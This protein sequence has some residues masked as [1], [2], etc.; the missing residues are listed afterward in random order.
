[1]HN[2]TSINGGLTLSTNQSSLLFMFIIIRNRA[3][4]NSFTSL[5]LTFLLLKTMFDSI[6]R[7]FLFSTWLY[8]I[9]EG[10]F[11][12]TKT[13]IAYYLTLFYLLIFNTIFNK[14]KDYTSARTWIGR[15][16]FIFIFIK[17]NNILFLEIFFNSMSSVLSYNN[18]DFGQMFE[19]KQ[20]NKKNSMEK[21]HESTLTK[22]ALYFLLFCFLNLGY[23]DNHF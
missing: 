3:K 22:Q 6:S 8:V 23:F 13:V 12:S 7:I 21:K 5:N 1:M 20:S 17:I 18:F 4:K 16:F 15:V 10:Q 9:N 14:Q 11:S 19:M 2:S